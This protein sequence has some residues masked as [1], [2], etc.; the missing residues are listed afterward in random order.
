M[1]EK[2]K[3]EKEQMTIRFPKDL[4][5]KIQEKADKEGQSFNSMLIILIQKSLEEE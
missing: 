3:I 5:N 4:K 2:Q 1:N